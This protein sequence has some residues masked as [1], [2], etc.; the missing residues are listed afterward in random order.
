MMRLIKFLLGLTV[1]AAAGV[2][3]APKS[4]RQLREQLFG[5]A[6]AKLL[7]PMAELY[8]LPERSLTELGDAAAVQQPPLAAPSTEMVATPESIVEESPAAV[9]ETTGEDLLARIAATRA[10]VEAELAEP[11]GPASTEESAPAAEPPLYW[12]LAPEAV[13]AEEPAREGREPEDLGVSE[14]DQTAAVPIETAPSAASSETPPAEPVA[15]SVSEPI[16]EAE[17][18]PTEIEPVAVVVEESVAEPIAAAEEPPT[19]IEPVAVVFEEP[20][21]R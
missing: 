11:F 6:A 20:A 14:A 3:F 5:G 7:P 8:P 2:L 10:A 1:G 17:E 19:E 21:D 4:G 12:E 13:A 15:E 16:A 9:P 18:P